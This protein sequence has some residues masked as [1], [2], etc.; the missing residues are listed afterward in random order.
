MKRINPFLTDNN[1]V[2]IPGCHVPEGCCSQCCG[3]LDLGRLITESPCFMTTEVLVIRQVDLRWFSHPPK[4]TESSG[5]K[6]SYSQDSD[7]PVGS[8]PL[9]NAL[10]T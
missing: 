8:I 9:E 4:L 5:T 1:P 7:N 6:I 2:P 3:P 10:E